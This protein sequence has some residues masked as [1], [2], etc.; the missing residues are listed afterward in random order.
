MSAGGTHITECR[1]PYGMRGLKSTEPARYSTIRTRRIPY[2]MRGL[3]YDRDQGTAAA[4][5]SH[6]IRD[7]WIEIDARRD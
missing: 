3:K 2:G 7:A 1:I 5:L 4:R 6:L